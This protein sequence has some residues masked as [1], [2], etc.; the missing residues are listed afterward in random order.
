MVRNNV[1]AIL[2]GNM[3][4][5][6][7]SGLYLT[8]KQQHVDNFVF[9]NHAKPKLQ[10]VTSCLR[11]YWMTIPQVHF[12][13]FLVSPDAQKTNAYQKAAIFYLLQKLK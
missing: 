2:T 8:D 10:A 9:I 3:T 5:T 4:E 12:M 13:S 6:N 1:K 7:I 11:L